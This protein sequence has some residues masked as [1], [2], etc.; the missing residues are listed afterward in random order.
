[1]MF[2]ELQIRTLAY[3]LHLK[4]LSNLCLKS[5]L[6]YTFTVSHFVSEVEIYAL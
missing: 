4:L 3:S 6:I 1:M 5:L 2:C